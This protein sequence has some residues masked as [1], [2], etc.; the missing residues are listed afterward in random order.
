M[1]VTTFKTIETVY[2]RHFDMSKMFRKYYL[3]SYCPYLA[4]KGAITCSNGFAR[5]VLH[6]RGRRE[7]IEYAG[8]GPL[9]ASWDPFMIMETIFLLHP[10]LQLHLR[11][12]QLAVESNHAFDF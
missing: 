5:Q 9:A 2:Q 8:V 11:M 6:R 3:R 1:T 12:G 7:F 10:V 4:N